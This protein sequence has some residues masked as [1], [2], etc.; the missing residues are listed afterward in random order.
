M[1]YASFRISNYY[2]RKGKGS[3]WVLLNSTFSSA[4]CT[5]ILATYV[6]DIYAYYSTYPFD[7]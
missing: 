3:N 1:S 4:L 6:N 5:S 2:I 7:D